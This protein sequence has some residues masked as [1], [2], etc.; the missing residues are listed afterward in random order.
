MFPPPSSCGRPSKKQK[1]ATAI[2]LPSRN[3]PRASL[4]EDHITAR[5]HA[6]AALA[7]VDDHDPPDLGPGTARKSER[8]AGI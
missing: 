5:P 8:D 3:W 2:H 1:P 7:R 6:G 4:L